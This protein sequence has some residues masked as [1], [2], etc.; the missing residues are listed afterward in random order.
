MNYRFERA[1]RM[2]KLERQALLGDQAAQKECTEK[3]IILPCPF[4]GGKPEIKIQSVQYGISGTIIRCQKCGARVFCLD[5]QAQTIKGKLVN[6]PIQNHTEIAIRRWN[7]R[8]S[9]P[10]GRCGE[11]KKWESD[12]CFEID[13]FCGKQNWGACLITLHHVKE[14]HYCSYFEARCEA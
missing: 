4:C 9:P 7:T 8:Q 2:T 12:G 10:I 6:V 14:N 5:A 13:N 3:G 1:R 11:C